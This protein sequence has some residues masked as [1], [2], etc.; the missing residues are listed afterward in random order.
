MASCR[1]PASASPWTTQP[2][3]HT[4][5]QQQQQHTIFTAADLLSPDD[6]T[7]MGGVSPRAAWNLKGEGERHPTPT[8]SHAAQPPDHAPP[9]QT[10]PTN[11]H[12]EVEEQTQQQQ[13]QQKQQQ[14][15]SIQ[16]E[17]A[18]EHVSTASAGVHP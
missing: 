15:A 17:A 10:A 2:P 18:K 12:K 8:P 4:P 16:A 6:M 13:K 7:G 9:S 1:E 3:T 14:Q 5:Q 11:T